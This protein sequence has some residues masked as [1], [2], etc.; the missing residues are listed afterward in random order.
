MLVCI[1]PEA[2]HALVFRTEDVKSIDPE[3]FGPNSVLS[4]LDG[5]CVT[6]LMSVAEAV[7]RLRDVSMNG[8]S[9]PYWVCRD[10]NLTKAFGNYWPT[11]H[12]SSPKFGFSLPYATK[13]GTAGPTE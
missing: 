13:T 1:N 11:S 12:F 8:S 5:S 7:K 10:E 2:K 3:C 6:L 9:S 4:L